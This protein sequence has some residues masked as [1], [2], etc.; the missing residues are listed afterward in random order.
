M[1]IVAFDPGK[2]VGVAYVSQ[3]GELLDHLIVELDA[4]PALAVPAGAQVV[5]GGGT[6]SRKLA[7]TL[8]AVG[9]EPE[10]IDEA[11]TTIEARVLYYLHN[12]P[13]GL[14]RLL[15]RGMRSPPVQLDDFA[16]YAIALRWLTVQ[17]KAVVTSEAEATNETRRDEP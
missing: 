7:A 1:L 17:A 5:V 15:P 2:N 16:A 3:A 13:R 14:T 12:P 4:V 11:S 10:V 9:H 6:G 8:R